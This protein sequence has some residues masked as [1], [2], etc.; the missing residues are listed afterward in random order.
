MNKLDIIT[1]VNDLA[2]QGRIS[3]FF[4]DKEVTNRFDV[5][6]IGYVEDTKQSLIS[7]S[8][9]SLVANAVILKGQGKEKSQIGEV[10]FK[11][12]F[13]SIVK[14]VPEEYKIRMEDEKNNALR[15][16][17]SFLYDLDKVMLPD[18][19][20]RFAPL[21]VIDLANDSN[22]IDKKLLSYFDKNKEIIF[23]Q[24]V[25]Y[26]RSLFHVFLTRSNIDSSQIKPDLNNLTNG[27]FSYGNALII[28][29]EKNAFY[30]EGYKKAVVNGLNKISKNFSLD[31]LNKIALLYLTKDLVAEFSF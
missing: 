26:T 10:S 12:Y 18:L 20:A 23:N 27:V 28:P 9:Y 17:N 19:L 30:L 5:N 6:G 7:F 11:T 29:T 24:A 13:D 2:D 1:A 21:V 31:G 8:L 16:L 25:L 22:K 4:N 3:F 14:K 15:T